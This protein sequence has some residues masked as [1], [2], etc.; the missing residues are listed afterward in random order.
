MSIPKGSVNFSQRNS[1]GFVAAKAG[2]A[3]I[4]AKTNAP[5]LLCRRHEKP[6]LTKYSHI[7]E[8]RMMLPHPQQGN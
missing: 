5:T 1:T 7:A 4:S 3:S 2:S 6:S 8:G